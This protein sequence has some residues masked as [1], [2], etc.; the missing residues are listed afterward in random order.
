MAS[1]S[2]GEMPVGYGDEGAEA[3]AVSAIVVGNLRNVG[4]AKSRSLVSSG[5]SAAGG[6]V[7]GGSSGGMVRQCS[8]VG[9]L[10]A[11]QTS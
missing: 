8:G 7:V 2:A 9:R 4:T 6:R 5:R 11:G 3:M 1:S 10:A